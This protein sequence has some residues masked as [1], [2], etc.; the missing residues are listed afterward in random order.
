MLLPF[1]LFFLSC[2]E[3]AY[4]CQLGPITSVESGSTTPVM[5]PDNDEFGIRP[6]SDRGRSRD[7]GIT[8]WQIRF[9]YGKRAEIGGTK[10]NE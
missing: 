1:S 10:K 8:R 4:G 5:P 6:L 9:R 3:E 2:E 7:D